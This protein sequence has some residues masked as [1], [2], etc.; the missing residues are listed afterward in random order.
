MN[1]VKRNGNATKKTKGEFFVM[2]SFVDQDA[3]IACGL[4]ACPPVRMFTILM[5][6][7]KQRLLK[8]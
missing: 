5:K 6:K 2:K 4:C 8:E 7:E 3:C 1:K